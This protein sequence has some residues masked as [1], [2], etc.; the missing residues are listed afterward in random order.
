MFPRIIL[1]V[2]NV[3]CTFKIYNMVTIPNFIAN[4]ARVS[5]QLT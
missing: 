5:V 3:K 1:R 4:Q 2:S